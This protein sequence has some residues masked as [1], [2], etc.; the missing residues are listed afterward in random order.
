VYARSVASE[1]TADI[2]PTARAGRGSG[3][4]RDVR[5]GHLRNDGVL[6]GV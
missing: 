5:W 2:C 4:D 6:G 3:R 1:P